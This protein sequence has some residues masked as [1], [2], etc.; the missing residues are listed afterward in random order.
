VNLRRFQVRYSN[1]PG[2][3][4]PPFQPLDVWYSSG[5]IQDEWRPRTNLTV[6]AGVRVDVAKFGNTAFDN[7][8]VDALTFRDRDGNPA[9]Y[10]T[11]ALPKTSPLWSPRVGFNYDLTSDQQTQLRGGTGVFTGK[12]A[13]VWIS[14]QIGNSGMLTGFI[15]SDNTTAFPW[16]PNP[17]AYKP[18]AT[19]QPP[20]SADVAV[21]DPD[22]RFP[23]TWRTNIAVDRR[24]PGGFVA[25]GEFIYNRDVNGMAYINAN[26]PGAQSAYAGAD[27]RPRWTANRINNTPGNVVVNNIV[28]LNQS[29]GRS[30]NLAA[31]VLRPMTHGFSFKSGYTYGESK[32]TIDPGSIASGSWTNNPVVL[33]PNNPV[34]AF[35]ANSPGHRFFLA[36]SYTHQYLNLGATTI[37]AFYDLHTNGNTSYIFSGDANGD[38]ATANDLIY[39]PRDMSEMNFKPLTAGGRTFTPG[40]QAAAFEAYIQQDSY[41]SSHRGQYA[42]R[43][44]LFYPVVGRLDLSL[45]Q[46]VFHAISGH[47]HSG[48]IRLDINNFG[49]LL[50]HDWG[51]G[52]SIIQNRILTSPST[53]ANGKL[54]YNFATLNTASGPALLSKTF[55]TT[56]AIG[57]TA[58][59][60]YVIMLSFRYTFQ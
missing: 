2:S 27:S 14:N 50:K 17:D 1:V 16:N 38:S 28:L 26:L 46:D 3:T 49:N 12:P 42:E 24:I 57:T 48:Q 51:V 47:R 20:A 45:V 5:Y 58:S 43:G 34:L 13:Y 23:Q 56:A 35:S 18:A 9:R 55:Q 11:G 6:T 37:A 52:Q 59:D 39:V 22:F 29:V 36:P 44:A 21:T 31:S 25:T 60:V 7:P 32:N 30:W 10:N 33:D 8:Q 41:L 4:N 40:D 54:T 19:G 15:Q 53:D